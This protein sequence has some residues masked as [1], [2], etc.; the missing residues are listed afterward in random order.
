MKHSMVKLYK[1]GLYRC[2]FAIFLLSVPFLSTNSYAESDS[3]WLTAHE[4]EWISGHPVIRIGPDPQFPPIE[5]INQNGEY[6]GIAAD[7]MQLV[8]NETG[9]KFQ[10]IQCSNW[11]DVLKKARARQID[12][13]PAAAL[14]P[15]R[16]AFLLYADPHLVFP[17]VIISR[18]IHA[19]P[20]GFSSHCLHRI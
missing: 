2:I 3:G 13:L 19:H 16:S 1:N 7:I 6:T 5:S 8:Q 12:A 20:A 15:E 11:H 9:I 4:K 17:G 10:V 14:T 18:R